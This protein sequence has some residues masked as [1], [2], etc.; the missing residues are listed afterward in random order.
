MSEK[1][2]DKLF[3]EVS[4]SVEYGSAETPEA[5]TNVARNRRLSLEETNELQR[6]YEEFCVESC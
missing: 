2:W 5:L 1:A 3:E 4:K 6:R